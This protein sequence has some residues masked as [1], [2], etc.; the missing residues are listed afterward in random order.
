MS[1]QVISTIE[2]T[3]AS[4]V[5]QNAKSITDLF[6]DGVFTNKVNNGVNIKNT[7]ASNTT[8]IMQSTCQSTAAGS[9][10]NNFVYVTPTGS[11]RKEVLISASSNVNASCT[12]TNLAKSLTQNQV[13]NNADQKARNIGMFAYIFMVLLA[14]VVIGGVVL[15]LL[16]ATGVLGSAFKGSGSGDSDEGKKPGEGGKKEPN[17]KQ[18]GGFGPKGQGPD[19]RTSTS[20]STS[21]ESNIISQI[22]KGAEGEAGDAGIIDDVLGEIASHPEFVEDVGEAIEFL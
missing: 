7:L 6:N 8:Q 20:Q 12:M 3:L 10:S 15:V 19:F 21:G 4:A 16:A 17:K 9:A 1:D 2:D 14:I 13:S 22:A 5:T 11:S 18:G